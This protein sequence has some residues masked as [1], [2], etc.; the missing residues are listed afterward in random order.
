M[1][2]ILNIGFLLCVFLSQALAQKT[3]RIPI[4]H[5][6]VYRIDRAYLKKNGVA[7]DEVNPQKTRFYY[8]ATKVLPQSNSISRDPSWKE[9]PV[10]TND[11]NGK[12]DRGDYILFYAESPHEVLLIDGK[13]SHQK[14]PYTDQAYILMELSSTDSKK[15]EPVS[16][17]SISNAVEI[18]TLTHFEFYD[19]DFINLLNSGREWYGEYFFSELSKSVTIPGLSLTDSAR[20]HFNI[21]GQTYEDAKLNISVNEALNNEVLLRKIRYQRNDYYRRY[22]RAGEIS[23]LEVIGLPTSESLSLNFQLPQELDIS[24]GAYLNYWEIEG[25]RSVGFYTEQHQAYLLPRNTQYEFHLDKNSNQFIWDV[26]SPTEVSQFEQSNNSHLIKPSENLT[27][28]A[29]FTLDNV[30]E[31]KNLE[32]IQTS[33]LPQQTPELLIVYPSY[34]KNEAIL[35]KDYR[36]EHDGLATEAVSLESIYH[37]YSGG[38]T[39]PTAIRD[40]C[41]DLWLQN[42]EKFKYLLLL[43]DTNFDYKNA[44]GLSYVNPERLIPSY[45]SKESLEPIYS[46]ASDDYFGFLEDHEGIWDEGQSVNGNWRP[47]YDNDHTL[48]IAVGR[49]PVKTKLEARQ[50]IEKLIS[51]D[52]SKGS[53]KRKVIFIADDADQNIHQRDA[54]SFSALSKIKNPELQNHKLYLDAYKQTETD[55]GERSEPAVSAFLKGMDEGALVVNFNGHGSEDGWTDEKLLTLR[56]ITQWRNLQNMPIFFTATCE[57]GRFDNPSVVSGAELALLNPNGGTPALL[58]TTRPVFSSTN[59]GINQA[60]YTRINEFERIGDVFKAT[61]ND[62]INGEINRNFSL[63]GDPSMRI[64]RPQKNVRL[65]T[66]NEQNPSKIELIGNTKFTFRGE[67]D[68]ANF[69]GRIRLS[70]YDKPISSS[71]LGNNSNTVMTY[72]EESNLLFQGETEVING[73]FSISVTPGNSISETEGLGTAYFYAIDESQNLEAE[74]SFNQLKLLKNYSNQTNDQLGPEVKF[75][76]DE[77]SGV[78][79]INTQDESGINTSLLDQDHQIQITVDDS[80]VYNLNEYYFSLDEKAGKINYFLPLSGNASLHTIQLKISDIHNNQTVESFSLEL[81]RSA[82]QTELSSFYPNPVEDILSLELKHDKPG[83]NIDFDLSVFNISGRLLYQQ[84]ESC[85]SCPS[86]VRFGMNLE[87]FI[88]ATGKYFLRVTSQIENTGLSSNTSAP[89]IFWK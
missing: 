47:N 37:N 53:W 11:S 33:D 86:Q 38:Q 83:A 75:S 42:P 34:F 40:Y 39:D 52:K 71:T 88:P 7:I 84:F 61:K 60:F 14:N 67:I 46:Y 1:L 51:Y 58:T 22:N 49:L 43:G 26:S 32:Q 57:F 5:D 6:G 23:S 82:F 31:P 55:L 44:N 68:D 56:E 19:P 59:F 66:I 24:S 36:A 16:L 30:L 29:F 72:E 35:L 4:E 69:N 79:T 9:I 25:K 77:S 64:N 78:L 10:S 2:K 27:K 28:L 41:R 21:V 80:L 81:S 65:I 48:D 85:T 74:G 50:V 3:Y 8:S 17:S 54:E 15:I 20:F 70:L 13:L 45:E 12:F 63:L 62:A 73:Q 89:L 76:Y 18:E 87:E